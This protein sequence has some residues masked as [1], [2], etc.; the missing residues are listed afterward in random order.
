MEKFTE[1]EMNEIR[2]AKLKRIRILLE[3]IAVRVKEIDRI[4]PYC[5]MAENF[6]HYDGTW[7]TRRLID[8]IDDDLAKD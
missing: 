5:N 4:D 3:E 1:H 6:L 7:V 2:K 8:M